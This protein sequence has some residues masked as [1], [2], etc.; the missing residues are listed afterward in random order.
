[1]STIPDNA[2][3]KLLPLLGSISSEL[4]LLH[5]ITSKGLCSEVVALLNSVGHVSDVIQKGFVRGSLEF[6][7]M[8]LM[9]LVVVAMCVCDCG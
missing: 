9:G 2:S 6:G 5:L 1:M 8:I 7:E 3:F 4:L